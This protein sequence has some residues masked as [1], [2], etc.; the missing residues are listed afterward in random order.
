MAKLTQR[1]LLVAMNNAVERAGREADIRYGFDRHPNPEKMTSKQ[2]VAADI[3]SLVSCYVQGI[4][5]ERRLAMPELNRMPPN[6]ILAIFRD[7][8]EELSRIHSPGRKKATKAKRPVK[9][10]RCTKS[11]RSKARAAVG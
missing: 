2:K 4:S 6:K 5:F 1:R 9:A 3:R 8:V 10:A 7:I 11:T